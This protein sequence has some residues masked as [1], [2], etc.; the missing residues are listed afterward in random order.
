M[1]IRGMSTFTN[2]FFIFWTW[3]IFPS[4]CFGNWFLLSRSRPYSGLS[5]ESAWQIRSFCGEKVISF[6]LWRNKGDWRQKCSYCGTASLWKLKGFPIIFKK[7]LH[8]LYSTSNLGLFF[9]V[10]VDSTRSFV[11][12]YL[13]VLWFR[14]SMFLIYLPWKF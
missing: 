2:T 6:P 7:I 14:D 12:L 9:N 11:F 5:G 3:A 13:T 4:R 10:H 1:W 8:F